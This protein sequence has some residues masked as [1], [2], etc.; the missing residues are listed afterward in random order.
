MRKPV[1]SQPGP[2]VNTAHWL[3]GVPK[4]FENNYQ[5]CSHLHPP[6]E[7]SPRNHSP[8]GQAETPSSNS[9]NTQACKPALPLTQEA[10]VSMGPFFCPPLGFCSLTHPKRTSSLFPVPTPRTLASSFGSPKGHPGWEISAN[11]AG[12]LRGAVLAGGRRV[13]LPRGG[14]PFTFPRKSPLLGGAGWKDY[15]KKKKKSVGTQKQGT[16]LEPA[17]CCSL[18]NIYR[19]PTVCVSAYGRETEKGRA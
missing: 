16:K 5:V 12:G 17:A 15:L 4:N 3:S 18:S 9:A 13:V 11:T 1:A 19:A 14:G 8:L 2:Q 6:N 10:Q 7:P